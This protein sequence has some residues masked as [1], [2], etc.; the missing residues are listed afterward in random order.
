MRIINLVIIPKNSENNNE[1]NGIKRFYVHFDR[2]DTHFK[3]LL[4]QV[5]TIPLYYIYY[6]TFPGT[7]FGTAYFDCLNLKLK[8]QIDIYI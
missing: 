1:F 8:I 6:S 4:F 3:S 2:N 7:V 5:A